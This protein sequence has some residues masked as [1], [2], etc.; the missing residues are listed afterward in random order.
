MSGRSK[1]ITHELHWHY[2]EI[3]LSKVHVERYPHTM[4]KCH[5]EVPAK[6]KSFVQS[7]VYCSTHQWWL[8]PKS[9]NSVALRVK[10]F[11]K[12]PPFSSN[13]HFVDFLFIYFWRWQSSSKWGEGSL[14]GTL[15]APH[16]GS[17]HLFVE[18]F[19]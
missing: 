14:I 16:G 1:C 17:P 9:E 8:W 13:K 5:Y 7:L 12:M 2:K 4:Y 6:W 3:W 18:L 11:H 19:H 15:G 10:I